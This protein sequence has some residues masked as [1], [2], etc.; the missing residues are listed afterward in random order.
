MKADKTPV[1]EW[2]PARI[3][4]SIIEQ[5]RQRAYEIY[6]DRKGGSGSDVED[7]LRAEAEI[8]WKLTH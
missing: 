5:I 7:W 4:E 3:H 6:L 1:T 2:A 8:M